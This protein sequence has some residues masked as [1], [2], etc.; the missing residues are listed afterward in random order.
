MYLFQDFLYDLTFEVQQSVPYTDCSTTNGVLSLDPLV[1]RFENKTPGYIYGNT[2]WSL[3]SYRGA[4]ET[5]VEQSGIITT[6]RRRSTTALTLY[7]GE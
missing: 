7:R 3:G 5:D 6:P 1:E 4:V 2:G